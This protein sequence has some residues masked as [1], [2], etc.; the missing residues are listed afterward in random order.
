[1]TDKRAGAARHKSAG[2]YG[3]LAVSALVVGLGLWIIAVSRDFSGIFLAQSSWRLAVRP[4]TFPPT[5]LPRALSGSLES[6]ATAPRGLMVRDARGGVP[7]HEG[8][9]HNDIEG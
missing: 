5:G 7:H 9:T 3:L 1:M 6:F 4:L 8:L 2:A